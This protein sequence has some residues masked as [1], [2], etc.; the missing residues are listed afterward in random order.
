MYPIFSANKS[1]IV[2]YLEILS[3]CALSSNLGEEMA[4]IEDLRIGL[5]AG[6]D[7]YGHFLVVYTR[8]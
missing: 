3:P 2:S 7:D 6:V 8:F 5:L 1:Y 4:N